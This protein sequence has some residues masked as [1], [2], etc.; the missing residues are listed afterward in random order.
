[1]VLQ[2]RENTSGPISEQA[3]PSGFRAVFSGTY[4]FRRGQLGSIPDCDRRATCLTSHRGI[5]RLSDCPPAGC[6]FGDGLM[7]Q[8]DAEKLK[9]EIA[10]RRQICRRL[11][12]PGLQDPFGGQLERVLRQLLPLDS[13]PPA[14]EPPDS[15]HEE[16]DEKRVVAAIKRGRLLPPSLIDGF[17][18]RASDLAGRSDGAPITPWVAAVCFAVSAFPRRAHQMQGRELELRMDAFLP[19]LTHQVFPTGSAPALDL[20]ADLSAAEA[21]ASEAAERRDGARLFLATCYPYMRKRIEQWW[22][23]ER[24]LVRFL[25]S[26]MLCV[27]SRLTDDNWPPTQLPRRACWARVVAGLRDKLPRANPEQ[28]MLAVELEQRTWRAGRR[29]HWLSMTQLAHAV[30]SFWERMLDKLSS[31]FP[32]YP[33][34]SQLSTWWQQ[35]LYGP[36]D[37]HRQIP[38]VPIAFLEDELPARPEP[39]GEELSNP[40]LEPEQLR[41]FREGYRLVRSTFFR[42]PTR[43]SSGEERTNEELRRA[44]DMIWYARLERKID[45]ELPGQMIRQ[46]VDE[47]PGL[48]EQTISSVCHRLRLRIWAYTLSRIKGMSD[49]EIRW[50]RIPERLRHQSASPFPL[51]DDSASSTVAN[52]ARTAAKEH[53][54]LWA[55]TARLWLHPKVD[56]RRPDPCPYRR[57]LGELWCWVIDDTLNSALMRGANDGSRVD[58][59]ILAALDSD[60]LAPLLADLRARKNRQQLDEFLANRSLRQE[61]M[62]RKAIRK[63]V[64][65][66][67]GIRGLHTGCRRILRQWKRTVGTQLLIPI[68]YSSVLQQLGQQAFLARLKI[69]AAE[70]DGPAR[71]SEGMKQCQACISD[72]RPCGS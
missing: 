14:S 27:P 65:R 58:R 31:G 7:A 46:I 10:R 17:K 50:T 25:R 26:Q 3:S 29:A 2:C 49:A 54:L 59:E 15:N 21:S 19:V 9:A 67:A 52:L 40:V 68:W 69:P 48:T 11:V 55:L 28:L 53:T 32:Y 20:L 47:F 23:S 41:W 71:V 44:A 30:E 22:E 1:M 64:R 70:H 8:D 56:P 34:L 51:A 42:R 12:G 39:H 60:P 61:K 13:Q 43:D 5:N 38:T 24:E 4:R 72:Q 66:L 63:I 45:G 36:L 62:E 57:Y 6:R 37:D 35:H 33:F 18:A 16:R